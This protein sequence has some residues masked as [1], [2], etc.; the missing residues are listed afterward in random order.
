MTSEFLSEGA[1]APLCS[2]V[3]SVSRDISVLSAFIDNKTQRVIYLK[4]A[5]GALSADHDGDQF[6]SSPFTEVRRNCK[7]S[8][9]EK[10]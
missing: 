10:V 4:G 5:N 6:S 1:I 3:P 7:N 9:G 8:K 2:R